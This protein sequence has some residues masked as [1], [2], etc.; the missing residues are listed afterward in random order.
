M[1]KI[2]A[3]FLK[4]DELGVE[5]DGLVAAESKEA[6]VEREAHPDRRKRK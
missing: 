5:H 3:R 2:A 6:V 1:V 4:L